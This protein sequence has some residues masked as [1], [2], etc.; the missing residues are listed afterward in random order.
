MDEKQKNNSDCN[1]ITIYIVFVS[2]CT[3]LEGCSR[4]MLFSEIYSW[5]GFV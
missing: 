4:L 2:S 1:N 5:D 3:V